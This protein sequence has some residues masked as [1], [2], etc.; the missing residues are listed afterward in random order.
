MGLMIC[1]RQS[2]SLKK[3]GI[4]GAVYIYTAKISNAI[5]YLMD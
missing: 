4:S 1:T 5:L 3:V 2:D